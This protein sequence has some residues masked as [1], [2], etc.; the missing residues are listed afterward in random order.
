M[1]TVNRS[2]LQNCISIIC[3]K[4]I[5]MIVIW[6]VFVNVVSKAFYLYLLFSLS[7]IVPKQFRNLSLMSMGEAMLHVHGR[8]KEHS[9]GPLV[10]H[11]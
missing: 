6:C 4:Q 2:T 5:I 8:M 10:F 9:G 3:Q 11:C 7:H 1:E